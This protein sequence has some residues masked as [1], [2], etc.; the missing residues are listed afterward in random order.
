M[1]PE[2]LGGSRGK[3]TPESDIYSYGM[4]VYEVF[5]EKLPFSET[6]GYGFKE[7]IRKILDED[8][9]PDNTNIPYPLLFIYFFK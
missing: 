3:P 4:L 2:L 6:P 7:L 8:F 5:M 9:R 1:A